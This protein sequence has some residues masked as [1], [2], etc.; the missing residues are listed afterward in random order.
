MA[1]RISVPDLAAM[2]SLSASHFSALFRKQMGYP[3]L[4]YQ[5]MLRMG[6]ARELLDTTGSTVAAIAAEVGYPDALYFTRQFKKLHG[7]TPREYRDQ[8]KG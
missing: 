5:T 2:A 3:V 8:H 7:A 4:Q 6:R 1:D